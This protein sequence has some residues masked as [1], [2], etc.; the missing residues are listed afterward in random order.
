MVLIIECGPGPKENFTA[1][2]GAMNP[3]SP[4]QIHGENAGGSR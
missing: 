3:F 2:S 4:S 1:T